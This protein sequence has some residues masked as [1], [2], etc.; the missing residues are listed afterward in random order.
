MATTCTEGD[1]LVEIKDGPNFEDLKISM[2]SFPVKFTVEYT[3]RPPSEKKINQGKPLS[4]SVKMIALIGLDNLVRLS[5]ESGSVVL[6]L[7]VY[8]TKTRTGV[9]FMR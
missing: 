3:H 4:F 2:G 6:N 8:N 9:G 7:V 5:A 1:Y